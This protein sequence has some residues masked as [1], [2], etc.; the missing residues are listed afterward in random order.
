MFAATGAPNLDQVLDYSFAEGDKLDLSALLDANFVSGSQV[1][2]FVKLVQTGTDITVQ[3]DV[4]GAAG[5]ASFA[6][7]AVLTNYGTTGSD[8]VRTWFGDAD[9]TLTV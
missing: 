2:D 4:N 9:Q 6:D 8:L 1:S 3:V 7:V 5:G